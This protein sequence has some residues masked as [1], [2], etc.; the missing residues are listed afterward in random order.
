M[1][2]YAEKFQEQHKVL[3]WQHLYQEQFIDQVFKLVDKLIDKS[4]NFI[5]IFYVSGGR[6][7]NLY[8]E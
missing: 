8:I 5:V 6:I 7:S 1:V 3:Y 2:L 4:K